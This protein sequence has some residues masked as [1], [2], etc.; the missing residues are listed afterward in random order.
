MWECPEFFEIGDTAF[1]L[2]SPQEMQYG[3]EFQNRHGNML[4]SGR[5]DP[6]THTFERKEVH[7]IDFGYDFYATQTL[8]SPDGRRIMIAWMQA[9]E[10]SHSMRRDG[11]RGWVGM[12]TLPRE[13]TV[14]DGRL[15]QTPVRELEAC[16]R[17]PVRVAD[18]ALSGEAAF[19]GVEG[20]CIDMTVRVAVPES[21]S[22]NRFEM[23]LAQNE[24]FRTVFACDMASGT[25]TFDRSQ[26]GY[27]NDMLPVRQ[28]QLDAGIRELTLRVIVDRYSVEIFVNGG[29]KVMT[30]VVDT[31]RDA[32][33]ISFAA[34]GCVNLNIEKYEIEL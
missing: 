16:R 7:A 15:I 4:I 8:L 21:A 12:T 24:A 32:Q 22:C 6:K 20:R 30:S 18:Y 34:D 23:R 27:P 29:E 28:M 31:P 19:P 26:S 14:K 5:Y 9:W 25:C 3:G 1:I 13:L 17:N 11:G 10:N 33:G 2:T